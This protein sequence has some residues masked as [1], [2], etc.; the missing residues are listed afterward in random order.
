[1]TSPT[2]NRCSHNNWSA[3]FPEAA[4]LS[5]FEELTRLYCQDQRVYH[6]LN[7][8]EHCL[9]LFDQ[10]RHLFKDPANIEAAL[11]IHDVIYNPQSST[12]ERDSSDWSET[13]FTDIGRPASEIA[14]VTKLIMATKKHKPFDNDS[15]LML[16]IDLSILGSSIQ[17]Y[18]YYCQQ[19]RREYQFVPEDKYRRRRRE[20]LINFMTRER[21]FISEEF[22]D[23]FEIQARKNL[24]WEINILSSKH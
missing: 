1:M 8:I 16:D 2:K 5:F 6:T 9:C 15:T 7:H 20:L 13:F 24:Q 3:L 11:W 19:I 10:Y 17:S 22:Y 4:G 18:K 23:N 12:N 14:A 21:I